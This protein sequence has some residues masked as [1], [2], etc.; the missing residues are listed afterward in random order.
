MS[1]GR[2]NQ[3]GLTSQQEKFAQEVAS[4]K[5]QSDAYRVAYP[6]SRQWQPAT[7]H[8]AASRLMADSKLSA[9]VADLQR[10]AAEF[11]GNNHNKGSSK[12]ATKILTYVTQSLAHSG[13]ALANTEW[14]FKLRPDLWASA[15]GCMIDFGEVYQKGDLAN[16]AIMA[17]VHRLSVTIL[18]SDRPAQVLARSL[19]NIEQRIEW[20][21]GARVVSVETWQDAPRPDQAPA[22]FEARNAKDEKLKRLRL[23]AEE[24]PPSHDCARR[25]EILAARAELAQTGGQS[26]A[27]RPAKG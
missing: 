16:L 6:A 23:M 17:N 14:A 8:Q 26:P 3:Y 21:T 9:R 24:D 22:V 4:G 10:A 15:Q 1:A 5:T 20:L 2:K 18:G 12:M 11:G 19:D 25:R 27:I 13:L 7:V